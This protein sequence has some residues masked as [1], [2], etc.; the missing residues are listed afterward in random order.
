MSAPLPQ[1]LPLHKQALVW[2]AVALVHGGLAWTGMELSRGGGQIASLWLPDAAIAAIALIWR[3]PVLRFALP[4]LIVHVPL[5]LLRGS[6][7]PVALCLAGS[8][9]LEVAIVVLLARRVLVRLDQIKD[10]RCLARFLGIAALGAAASGLIG[11]FAIARAPAD[12]PV[13]L[14]QWWLA[15]AMAMMSYAPILLV[16]EAD[17]QDSRRRGVPLLT[18]G[19]AVDVALGAVAMGLIFAQ[20]SYPFLFFAAPVVLAVAARRGSATSAVLLLITALIATR[21]TMNGYGPIN[22]VQADM[23][24]KAAVLQVFIFATFVSTLPVTLAQERVEALR[25]RT[26]ALFDTMDEISFSLDLAGRWTYLSRHWAKLF[27]KDQ[28]LPIG[29]R[30]LAIVPSGQRRSVLNA[31]TSLLNGEIDEAQFDF[32]ANAPQP[33]PLY[34]NLRVR[35]MPARDG[36]PEAFG[37]IIRDISRETASE[38]ALE[39]SERRLMSLAENAPVGVFQFDNDGNATFL[40]DEWARMHGMTVEEGLGKGWQRIFDVEQ[41][42]HYDSFAAERK[43]G[44]TTDIEAVVHRPDGT[45][46]R[47]R[48]VTTA[49]HGIDGEVIGRMGVVVDQTREY[50]AREALTAALEEAKAASIAK[51]R[52]LALMSHEL[53]T[54]MNGVLGFAERL[55]ETQLK[56]TQRRY[57]SL[58]SRS[59]E[60]MLALL[61]DILDTS[62]MREGQLQIAHAPYDLAATL[63]NICQHFEALAARRSLQLRCNFAS[64]LPNRVLGDQQRL[65]QVLN[66]LLGNALKFTE[67]GWISVYA[68][69]EPQYDR[70]I[71]IVEVTDTGIG[72]APEDA[73]RVFEAFDQGAKDT[74]MRFGGTGLGLPIALGLAKQMGGSLRLVTSSIGKG[75]IFRLTLPLDMPLE[76]DPE[77]IRATNEPAFAPLRPARRELRLLVAEDN[78]I[79]RYLIADLLADSGC[80][81][82]IV[83]DGQQAVDAVFQAIEW[84]KPFDLLLMDL[85]MPV[86]DGVGATTAIRARGVDAAT[87][88]I[89]AV[90][91]SVHTDAMDACWQAGMQDYVTKP[92]TRAAIDA[93]LEKWSPGNAQ[94]RRSKEDHAAPPAL[95]PELAP[96]LARFVDQCSDCLKVVSNMLRRWPDDDP[97]R[98]GDVQTSAHAVAGL[99]ATFAAPQIVPPAQALD[100]SF[101]TDDDEM[102]R[103]KLVTMETA[104]NAY[105]ASVPKEASGT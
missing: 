60:V 1:A 74:A 12:I 96:L 4:M 90:T 47:I 54:P 35:L 75:S 55:S 32:R 10:P 78:E 13:V 37:G 80:E 24:A 94:A 34:L 102:I 86:L 67:E 49:V 6:A 61:N 89:V 33:E 26:L 20:T 46:C 58:I 64:P 22:L 104:L 68:R 28:P 25:E 43:A 16:I 50:E 27:D 42:T 82:T 87:L 79:N 38:R 95:P 71:L 66:N 52:F 100:L 103:E 69:I 18:R 84:G 45:S 93:A 31:M 17:R 62:R 98:R 73:E 8:N 65:T 81:L 30:A 40:N 63:T 44:A 85:R 101:D 70:T 51:D 83:T 97:A 57:V 48:A 11:S 59:G 88:P 92:V 14:W 99:A 39:A 91:A 2:F 15:H 21:F 23:H 77:R 5:V 76:A 36:S 9:I 3:M 19:G 7:L 56:E 72:I 29:R 53:R 105:L 41:Q